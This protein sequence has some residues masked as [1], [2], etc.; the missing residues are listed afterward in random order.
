M[1]ASKKLLI[2][3]AAAA[4][5]TACGGDD[6]PV[7]PGP[8]I[9]L[10][11][12]IVELENIQAGTTE[13]ESIVGARNSSNSPAGLGQ[14]GVV[15]AEATPGVD[16]YQVAAG[17]ATTFDFDIDADGAA[18]S[19]QVFFASGG[20]T[21][22][23]WEENGRCRLVFHWN[24]VGWYFDSACGE[25]GGLVCRYEAETT[26]TFC[27][28]ELCAPCEF[29]EDDP[30]KVACEEIIPPEPEPEPDV[31]DPEPDIVEPDVGEDVPEPDVVED[32]GTDVGE[33]D[34]VEPD[35]GEPDTVEPDV[36]PSG[37]C[38]PSCMA[39][40]DAVCCTEC[41]CAASDCRPTCA[42]PY[43]WDCEVQCCFDY[44]LLQC[45]GS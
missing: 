13:A 12:T 25:D 3:T 6:E 16:I 32:T 4:L 9:V 31:P 15:P 17:N 18:E 1:I 11:T 42:S 24:N 45:E 35:V 5:V 21:Y 36:G 19:V 8:E 26:C 23:G 38:D 10:E 7:D 14:I 41:G 29:D 34:T 39:A 43:E 27:D 37:E 33:P 22:L 40:P 30:N 20:P 2:C 44:D 28:A